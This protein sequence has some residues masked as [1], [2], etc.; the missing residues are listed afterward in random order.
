MCLAKAYLGV[1]GE[2]EL[3]AE[4]VTSL[5]T[6]DGKLLL[7]TLFGEQ[8]EVKANITEIDFKASSILLE[9]APG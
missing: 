8:K 6:N 7:T 5:K 4:D 3:L 1:S 9:K 2:K